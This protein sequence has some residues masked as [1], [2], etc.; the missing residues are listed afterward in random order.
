MTVFADL[1]NTVV[2]NGCCIGCGVCTFSLRD[3]AIELDRFGRYQAVRSSFAEQGV[4]AGSGS[5]LG[6]VCPFA[7]GT[8]SEDEIAHEVF[9]ASPSLHPGLGRFRS[10]WAGA[11]AE[12][13]FRQQGSSGGLVT[14]LCSELLTKGHVHGVINVCS[15]HPSTG[16]PNEKLFAFQIARAPQELRAAAKSR[17]Y[18]VELSE[19]LRA[20][21]TGPEAEY[22]LVGVPCFIK[23]VRLLAAADPLARRR[24]KYFIGLVCGHLKSAAFADMLAWQCGIEPGNL[25]GIDFRVKKDK[26]RADQYGIAVTGISA[27]HSCSVTRC[28]RDFYGQLWGLGFFKYEA[29]DY[30]DD[31]FAETADV[32]VGDAWLPPYVNDPGGTNVLVVRHPLFQELIDAGLAE[33]RLRLRRLPPHDVAR[34]QDAGLRHRRE[35]LAYRLQVRARNGVWAP[36]KRVEPSARVSRRFRLTHELRMQLA[37]ESHLA[38]ATAR[39]AGDFGVFT[40]RMDPLIAAYEKGRRPWRGYQAMRLWRRYSTRSS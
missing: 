39:D 16:P 2:A 17:Y 31:V 15:T 23:A 9:G 18:P 4:D 32:S 33:D 36:H 5:D 35:G 38:F 25:K 37:A 28:N 10:T 6:A 8:P 29:C 12:G 20:V 3:V 21:R 40:A 11:V 14:W 30:C 27:G 26:G 1:A 13:S 19:V 24:F 7:D 22:A 34:S